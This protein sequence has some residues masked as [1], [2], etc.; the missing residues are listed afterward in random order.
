MIM[1]K[2]SDREFVT[3]TEQQKRARRNRSVALGL[4]LAAL[5]IVFY[6]VTILK[7]DP[8]A[9]FNRQM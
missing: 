1:A 5:V 4:G 3:M 8:S 6:V 9:L 7:V 2:Q